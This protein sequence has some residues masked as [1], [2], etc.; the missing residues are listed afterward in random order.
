VH[1]VHRIEV[2]A[3]GLYFNELTVQECY[4][5][6]HTGAQLWVLKSV[7][8]KMDSN[9]YKKL[10]W[11]TTIHPMGYATSGLRVVQVR[12]EVVKI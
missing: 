9:Y 1:Q 8:Y 4:L 11:T 3:I 7:N 10:S 6:Q 5:R 2:D 12:E